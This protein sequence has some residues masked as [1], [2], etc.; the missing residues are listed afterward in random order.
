MNDFRLLVKLSQLLRRVR[1]DDLLFN[2]MSE[3]RAQ[4]GKDDPNRGL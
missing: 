1:G 4:L 3:E 2:G